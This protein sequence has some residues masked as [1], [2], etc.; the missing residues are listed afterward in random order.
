M[1]RTLAITL[2]AGLIAGAFMAAPA[3]ARRAKAQKVTLFL[4]GNEVIG[5][6]ESMSLI[7]DGFLPM[8]AEKPTAAEPRSRF[9]TN[10]L[11][12]PNYSCAGNNLF[13]VWTGEVSGTI[14]GDMKVTLH[15][16]GTP[17]TVEVRV[18]PDV[19][20]QMC[21][22]TIPIA[23]ADDYPDPLGAVTVDLP[24]GHGH[25]EA[26]IKDVNFKAGALMMLQISP[27][28]LL[29]IPDPGGNILNPFVQRILYDTPDL[30]S[31]IEFSC[32]PARGKSCT[33]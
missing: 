31:S 27:V 1:K 9:I 12:G 8:S 21:N 2:L 24:A 32:I 33:P 28:I 22:S 18:W 7:A 11:V 30:A 25:V 29:D 26:V 20:T 10:Y 5:E 4:H 17:G 13:P 23:P 6:T 14:K 16:V 15:T 3:E 19:N